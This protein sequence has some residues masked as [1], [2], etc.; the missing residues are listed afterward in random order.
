MARGR[1]RHDMGRCAAMRV[2]YSRHPYPEEWYVI[3]YANGR[4][5]DGGRYSGSLGQLEDIVRRKS[6]TMDED[7]LLRRVR[8]VGLRKRY[9]TL[10]RYRNGVRIA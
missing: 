5:V 1:A 7:I 10:F 4:S 9:R 8:K 2:G 6:R 3:T